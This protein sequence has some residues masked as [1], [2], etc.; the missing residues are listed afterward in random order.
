MKVIPRPYWKLLKLLIGEPIALKVDVKK[1]EVSDE[2]I[3][4]LGIK[5]LIGENIVA[6]FPGS[7]GARLQNIRVGTSRSRCNF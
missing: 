7:T 4:N 5:E 6:F 1:A 3:D 2:N